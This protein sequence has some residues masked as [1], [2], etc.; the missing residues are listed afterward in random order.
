MFYEDTIAA[1]ATASV[2]GGVSIIRISGENAVKVADSCL[3]LKN[4]TLAE[5]KSHTIHYGYV[6]DEEGQK[7]D[8]VIVLLMRTPNSYTREDVVEIQCHGGTFVCQT[9]LDLI[10]KKEGV[11]IAEPGEFTKR[12]FLNGRIDLSQAEAVMDLIESK[13]KYALESS[14]SQLSGIVK[15]KIQ[16][17]R[18]II[19]DDVAY[20]E[21]A[22]DD[23]E[24]ISLDLFEKDFLNHITSSISELRKMKN[25][26]DNGRLIYE[27]IQTAIIGKPNVGKSSFLNAMLGTERAI[28]TNVPGTTRDTL[29]ENVRIG[30]VF[31]HLIDT[32]GIH[33]TE[34]E[35]E[36][37]GIE[38]AREQL[39][40]CDFCILILD[41]SREIEEE[42][43]ILLKEIESKK[44]VI[45]YN[46]S[47]LE[48]AFSI[49]EIE[50]MTTKKIIAFSAK[51][52][53]GLEDLQ[54]YITNQF[55]QNEISFNQEIYLSNERQK[56]AVSEAYE[57][58][59]RVKESYDLGVG[60]DFYTI[61]MMNAYE[62]LGS[63]IGETVD[64]DLVDTIFKKFCMGK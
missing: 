35:V 5:V 23:P 52:G 63:I 54:Q 16:K 14:V 57:S 13:S 42:D 31:L 45:L 18:N 17:I 37:I 64:D 53:E 62:Q 3:K 49:D 33:E 58:L 43:K 41:R 48:N 4:K 47:D 38:K 15:Q 11:R 32:A 61:D 28:V 1:I 60:E 25:N 20:I 21:A 34:D 55:F 44:A 24:H 9:I 30:D 59:L 6:V 46:K 36:K 26:Y 7:I 50:N 29:E 51:T 19:M 56:Q 10:L 39:K 22:L 12:A 2:N 27:G 40:H 8:E